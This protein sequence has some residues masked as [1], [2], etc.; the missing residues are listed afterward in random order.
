AT[1]TKVENS[2]LEATWEGERLRIFQRSG[3]R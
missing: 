2:A 3:Q 1:G